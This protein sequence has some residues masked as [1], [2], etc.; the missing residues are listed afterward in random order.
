MTSE[1]E[2]KKKKKLNDY[3]YDNHNKSNEKWIQSFYY[4]R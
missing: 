2:I 4:L 3:D 1:K